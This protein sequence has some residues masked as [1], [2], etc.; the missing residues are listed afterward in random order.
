M[1]ILRNLGEKDITCDWVLIEMVFE[2][3]E[4]LKDFQ[5]VSIVFLK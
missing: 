2:M 4:L 3:N 1:S 5:Q